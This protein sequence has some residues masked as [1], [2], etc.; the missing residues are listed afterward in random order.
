MLL[1]KL[2]IVVD[3][4]IGLIGFRLLCVPVPFRPVPSSLLDKN[5]I[6]LIKVGSPTA[7][8]AVT[9]VCDDEDIDLTAVALPS[10]SSRRLN[11]LP[12]IPITTGVHSRPPLSAGA[13]GS[14]KGLKNAKN[15]RRG[16]NG[17]EGGES[18]GIASLDKLLA[19]KKD[20]VLAATAARKSTLK[21]RPWPSW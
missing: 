17:G 6:R 5:K 8:A 20:P 10:S 11:H 21:D 1:S 14:G 12:G 4:D 13:A 15:G 19:K 16:E 9:A 7:Q 2:M 3:C 18:C